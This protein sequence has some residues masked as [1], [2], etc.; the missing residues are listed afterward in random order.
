MKMDTRVAISNMKYHKGKNVIIGIAILLTSFLLFLVPTMGYDL[1]NGQFTVVN[2][3]Y[4]TWHAI[5]R[6]IDSETAEKISNYHDI[7]ECGLR[8]DIGYINCDDAK[9]SLMTLDD[10][11]LSL[12]RISI[13]EGKFPEKENE[14]VVSPG[15]LKAMGIEA[16]IGDTIKLPYQVYRNGGLD[17]TQEKEFVISG[18]MA[19]SEANN[20][21]KVYTAFASKEFLFNEVSEDD[22][23]W[24]AVIRIVGKNNAVKKDIEKNIYDMADQ[25][26]VDKEEV[27]LNGDY[28]MA[29]YIDPSVIPI[30][31]VI[32]IIIVLAGIIT[33]Y[34]IYYVNMPER[35]K[36]YGRLKAIGATR[37]QIRTVVLKEGFAVTAIALPLGLI[38]GTIL[39][40][41]MFVGLLYI[42]EDENVIVSTMKELLEKKEI[43]LY[44]PWIYVLAIV[45]T[46]V[47]VYVSLLKPMKVASSISEIQAMRY[48]EGDASFKVRSKSV[49]N[50]KTAKGNKTTNA[51]KTA[52]DGKPSKRNSSNKA[53][54]SKVKKSRKSYDEMNIF[55]L[56]KIYLLKNKKNSIITIVSMGITGV[57]LMVI[58]TVLSCAN[59]RESAN[60]SVL[61]QY[62]VAINTQEG[63]KEHPEREWGQVVK[64]SPMDDDLLKQLEDIDGIKSVSVFKGIHVTSIASQNQLRK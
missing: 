39:T 31:A 53:T 10:T 60:N 41:V 32:M 34:S 64:N 22:I 42:Y 15:I 30:I 38:I 11:A 29:N 24:Y 2:E 57:F 20:K 59:P 1:I 8:S 16:K 4:P 21:Q 27:G 14:I 17:Y 23:S 13:D 46:L 25:F 52:E 56:S 3:I 5:I 58:A 50:G 44:N 12:Y 43:S 49:K 40:R 37:H 6:N 19:D 61:G 55:R 63:N 18:F 36:E 45:V 26:G 35:I 28:L 47:T 7:D 9:I 33:I 51:D 54:K 62:R 48:N